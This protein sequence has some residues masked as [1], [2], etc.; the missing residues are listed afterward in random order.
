MSRRFRWISL[1]VL[2][3]VN[4]RVARAQTFG[5][6]RQNNLMPD[7][8]GMAETSIRPTRGFAVPQSNGTSS[9]RGN[10]TKRLA[11]GMGVKDMKMSG[12][13][14]DMFAGYAFAASDSFSTT[15]MTFKDNSWVG[16]GIHLA[17]R[18]RPIRLRC[19]K[20]TLI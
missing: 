15:S 19:R 12:L 1:C 16:A 6:E 5:V 8:G 20:R 14:F 3:A 13:D 17:V 11:I 4:G 18:C 9:V 2:I 10:H 7:S